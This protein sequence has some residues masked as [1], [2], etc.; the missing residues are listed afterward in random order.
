M[1]REGEG[2][3]GQD[4][5]YVHQQVINLCQMKS[6]MPASLPAYLPLCRTHVP[7]RASEFLRFAF[8]AAAMSELLLVQSVKKRVS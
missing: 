6:N 5:L 3:A 7:R 2:V 4:W 8:F 1:W